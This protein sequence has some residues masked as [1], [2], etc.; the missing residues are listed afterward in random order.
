MKLTEHVYML[1]GV[2]YSTNSNTYAIR[3]GDRLLLID[4]GYSSFQWEAM[5]RVLRD[6]GL[7]SLPISHLFLTHV[8]FD[9]AGNAHRVKALGAKICVSEA[10][11]VSLREG[12]ENTL[13]L[14]T[15]A[16]PDP[17]IPCEPD[18]TLR[19]GDVLDFGDVRL[20]VLEGRGHSAGSLLFLV[21]ADGKRI[22]FTGDCISI[23]PD[24][25]KDN[26]LVNL[27]WCG[28]PDA[29]VEAYGE[30]LRRAAELEVDIL[31]PGHYHPFFGDTRRLFRDAI[32]LF[33]KQYHS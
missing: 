19:P 31:A 12:N 6:W 14:M 20:E 7:D 3:A 8:H 23:G 32:A 21:T 27:A 33:E 13:R 16:F 17:F 24:D 15:D 11:G 4:S 25:A 28:G 2:P 22:L 30:T 9:H 10:D 5:N 29:N 18:L 26:V 1:S